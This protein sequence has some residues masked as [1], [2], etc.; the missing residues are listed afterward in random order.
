MILVPSR[1][2]RWNLALGRLL[3]P[4][5]S[6]HV[7]YAGRHASWQ[8]ACEAARGWDQAE[9][10]ETVAAATAKV[11]RGEA[12]AERDSVLLD[13]PNYSYPVLSTVLRAA[14]ENGGRVC[15]L[16]FGG[17]LGSSYRDFRSFAPS[18]PAVLWFV[19]EQKHFV[20]RGRAQFQ[21]AELRFAFDI[22]EVLAQQKPDV[23]LLS[24]VLQFI[25]EPDRLLEDLA[26]ASPR[27]LVLDRTPFSAA[28]DDIFTVQLVPSRIYRASYACRVFAMDRF[29]AT[30]AARWEV[31]DQF[32]SAD[33][34]ACAG[35][36][37][38]RYGGM[39]L[40]RKA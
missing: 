34:W 38:F 25:E 28:P 5:A 37:S 40:Q 15:V 1:M 18:S 26:A 35:P 36:L 9:I 27:Y 20:E 33:G 30:L 13:T 17:S 22:A 4:L 6:G 2:Q 16:D 29:R 24:G 11:A 14:L 31:V 7:R 23:V 19:V 12:V 3:A 8:Q 21:T 32:P 10:L 39:L